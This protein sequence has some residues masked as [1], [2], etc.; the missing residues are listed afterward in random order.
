MQTSTRNKT[1]E[2]AG[3]RAIQILGIPFALGI[4]VILSYGL[5]VREVGFYWDDWPFVLVM[6]RVGPSGFLEMLGLHRP[7]LAKL[8][9]LTT[10]IF[11]DHP[12]RWQLFGLFTRWLAAVSIWWACREFWPLHRRQVASIAF[13]FAVYPGFIEQQI[14]VVYSHYFLVYA[15]FAFSLGTM[16]IAVRGRYWL[17]GIVS[18]LTSA[19]CMFSIQYYVGLEIARPLMIW[20]ILSEREKSKKKKFLEGWIVWL[21]YLVLL[22]GMFVWRLFLLP[23]TNYEASLLLSLRENLIGTIASVFGV[24]VDDVV[25]TSFVAW[26][27]TLKLLDFVDL[28]SEI[29]RGYSLIVLIVGSA[30]FGFLTLIKWLRDENESTA[31]KFQTQAIY[32]GLLMI[33]GA[34]WPFWIVPFEIELRFP[35]DRFTL[36]MMFASSVLL[37]GLI[38]ALIKSTPKKMFVIA[39]LVGFAAGHHFNIANTYKLE[40]LD[41]ERFLWQLSWRIPSLKPGTAILVDEL[42]YPY[43]DDQAMSAVVNFMYG[44]NENGTILPY[45]FFELSE[46]IHD[47]IPSIAENENISEVYGPITFEGSTSQAV[48]IAYASE[49]CLRVLNP[50]DNDRGQVYPGALSEVVILSNTE[51]ILRE[52]SNAAQILPKWYGPLKNKG[53]CYYYEQAE[54]ARQ[55]KDWDEIVRLGE[56]AFGLGIEPFAPEELFPFIEG[57]AV[58]GDIL[59]A[60]K[61]SLDVL[62]ASRTFR[63]QICHIWEKALLQIEDDLER[64]AFA[65][66]A[67]EEFKCE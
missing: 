54:L 49:T 47:E 63:P 25:E 19:Y 59:Q 45:G 58:A 50:E 26:Q 38:E 66:Q 46:S 4:L 48:V 65:A 23:E 30:A 39:L 34:G 43:S 22:T 8:Y 29:Q 14:A 62:Q 51:N 5:L 20:Y 15:V 12:L 67:V 64:Q 57:Y 61:L 11:A 56:D 35:L 9:G 16:V 6:N 18:I 13:L 44:K 10:M 21:P 1:S 37:A 60:E 28:K 24:I 27:R 42:P 55:F 40:W 53:W 41:Q 31:K 33:F 2:I 3:S 32:L 36:P 17:W 52:P 7:L